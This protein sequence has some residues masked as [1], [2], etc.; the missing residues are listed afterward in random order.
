M[1]L[2]IRDEHKNF[3][4]CPHCGGSLTALNQIRTAAIR[5]AL[6]EAAQWIEQTYSQ[7]NEELGIAADIRALKE[8]KP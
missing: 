8:R 7:T 2:H 3:Y 5:A 4:Y 1:S 6:E